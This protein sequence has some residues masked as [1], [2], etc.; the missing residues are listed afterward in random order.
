MSKLSASCPGS[1]IVS[2][3]VP[4]ALPAPSCTATWLP[5][6][7]LYRA[8]SSAAYDPLARNSAPLA[9]ASVPSVTRT[10]RNACAPCCTAVPTCVPMSNRRATS[11]PNARA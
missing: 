7:P 11:D 2:R 10:H 5:N 4:A 3:H 6:V 1:P 9:A 8:V